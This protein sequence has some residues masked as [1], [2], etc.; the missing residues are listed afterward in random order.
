ME[1]R[2]GCQYSKVCRHEQ[3]LSGAEKYSL[4]D[5]NILLNYDFRNTS[6]DKGEFDRLVEYLRKE[7]K[8]MKVKNSEVVE[9][10]SCDI[11]IT[12]INSKND[13]E[14]IYWITVLMFGPT[15]TW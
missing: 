7:Q 1:L 9:Y 14:N 8:H 5:S 11:P 4:N 15:S 2:S 10:E 6:G 3:L 13:L 12:Y